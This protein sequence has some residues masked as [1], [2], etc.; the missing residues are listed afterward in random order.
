MASFILDNPKIKIS[1]FCC[2]KCILFHQ[3]NRAST[4]T[5][6]TPECLAFVYRQFCQSISTYGL[7][8][9]TLNMSLLIRLNIRQN[10]F[11][12][13]GIDI[14]KHYRST[15]LMKSLNNI[16]TLDELYTK[17]KVQFLLRMELL[18]SSPRAVNKDC[19]W[20]WRF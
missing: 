3:E 7:E 12:K 11:I 14:F 8:V 15:P 19:Y 17:A 16:I 5:L 1:I 18:I 4:Q 10:I 6:A 20:K 2:W 9:I 13:L